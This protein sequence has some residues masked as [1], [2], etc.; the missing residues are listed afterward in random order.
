MKRS[1]CPLL[2]SAALVVLAACGDPTTPTE[3]FC[4]RMQIPALVGDTVTTPSGLTYIDARVGTGRLVASG[5]LVTVH[6]TAY[7]QDGTLLD[8]SRDREPS[9]FLL[10]EVIAGF[11]EGLLGMRVGGERRLIVPPQLGYGANPP[12]ESCIPANATMI[13]D[14]DLLGVSDG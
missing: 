4:P 3:P 13:F 2:A 5:A 1:L 12:A 11:A 9:R 14:V 10:Q 7:L 8:S 6:Y